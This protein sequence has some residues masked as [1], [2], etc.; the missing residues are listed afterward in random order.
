MTSLNHGEKCVHVWTWWGRWR[1]VLFNG[2]LSESLGETE[3][4]HSWGK[5][6]TGVCVCVCVR[7]C[8]R[9]TCVLPP[10]SLLCL[11][12][13]LDQHIIHGVAAKWLCWLESAA[14]QHWLL[15]K[16]HVRP[17]LSQSA[18]IK[19]LSQNRTTPHPDVNKSADGTLLLGGVKVN[20][21]WGGWGGQEEGAGVTAQ[22]AQI[23]PNVMHWFCFSQCPLNRE[24]RGNNSVP[25]DCR[26]STSIL[27][28]YQKNKFISL[29]KVFCILKI[30]V[31]APNIHTIYTLM[32]L[33]WNVG[34]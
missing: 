6:C 15:Y 19:V 29:K 12:P 33:K 31:L 25:G 34:V 8:V 20:D 9:F 21:G 23:N 2:S 27:P 24:L 3:C 32:Y 17:Y 14:S 18:A 16:P 5:H 26:K 13:S 30:H 10:S 22:H 28:S 4:T 11:L 7:P 1:G